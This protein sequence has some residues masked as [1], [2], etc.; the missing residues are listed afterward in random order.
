MRQGVRTYAAMGEAPPR[1][2][3]TR[4][5]V[6]ATIQPVA[7]LR[8]QE[9]TWENAFDGIWACASLLHVPRAEMDAVLARLVRALRPGGVW[10]MSFKA[11]EPEEVRGGRLFNDQTGRSLR[12]LLDRQPALQPGRIWLTEDV[13]PDRGG[14]VW[15]NALVRKASRV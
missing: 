5:A 2:R 11:G 15:L 13:R 8:F 6:P 3:P 1:A 9:V 4:Q 14:Q 10:Y 7:V 12:E